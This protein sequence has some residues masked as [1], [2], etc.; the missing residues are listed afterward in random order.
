MGEGIYECE[1]DSASEVM[2]MGSPEMEVLVAEMMRMY[3][4]QNDTLLKNAV[5]NGSAARDLMRCGSV[6]KCSHV[7][8]ICYG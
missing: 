1:V 5:D 6:G 4:K 3:A 8:R 7:E 2:M